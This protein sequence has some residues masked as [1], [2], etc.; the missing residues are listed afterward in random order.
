[1]GE[2]LLLAGLVAIAQI[3]RALPRIIWAI[4]CPA[5][6]RRYTCPAPESSP[7]NPLLPASAKTRGE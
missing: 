1:M 4:R 2:I 5:G 3:A 7:R 6:S